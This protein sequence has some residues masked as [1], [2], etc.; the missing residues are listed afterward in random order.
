MGIMNVK[1]GKEERATNALGSY[2]FQ[3]K[4]A[5]RTGRHFHRET[6][7]QQISGD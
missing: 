4:V 5:A 7:S 1:E 2:G 3:V 6:E